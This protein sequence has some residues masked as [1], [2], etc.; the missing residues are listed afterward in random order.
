MKIQS[1]HAV[2][3][4]T[5]NRAGLRNVINKK[6]KVFVRITGWIIGD[7]GPDDGVSQEFL[8]D[9]VRVDVEV[10]PEKLP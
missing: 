7:D 5:R 6:Q 1:T 3:D 4:V 2:L 9:V 8:I 10:K